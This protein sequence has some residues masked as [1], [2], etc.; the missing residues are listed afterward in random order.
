[1]AFSHPSLLLLR[2]ERDELLLSLFELIWLLSFAF[3]VFG[4]FLL[5]I[6]INIT[7]YFLVQNNA[8][9]LVHF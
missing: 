2:L 5:E 6:L 1:M 9:H 3:H 4:R 7:R 8:E